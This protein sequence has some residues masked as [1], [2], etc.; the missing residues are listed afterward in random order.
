MRG[1]D[2]SFFPVRLSLLDLEIYDKL[3]STYYSCTTKSGEEPKFIKN[4]APFFM[5]FA[6]VTGCEHI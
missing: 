5:F 4:P 3:I 6:R 1:T 2:R